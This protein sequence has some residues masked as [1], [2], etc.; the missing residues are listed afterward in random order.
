MNR[1]IRILIVSRS[2]W[3]DDNSTGNTLS[4]FFGGQSNLEL[5]N[6]YFRSG[7]PSNSVCNRYFSLSEMKLFGKNKGEFEC[8]DRDD[9][10]L[11]S[12]EEI[13]DQGF[14]SKERKVVE[15]VRRYKSPL[16]FLFQDLFWLLG[17]WKSIDF[18]KFL[19]DFKPDVIFFPSF[20]P[21]YTHKV[22][23][24]VL[25]RTGAKL[26]VFHTDDYIFFDSD[27]YS[28]LSGFYLKFRRE[29]IERTARLAD[30]N[31]CITGVQAKAYQNHLG[32]PFKVIYKGANLETD[33]NCGVSLINSP[34]TR[35]VIRILYAGSLLYGRWKALS[36]LLDAVERTRDLSVSFF[37]DIYSQYE[38]SGEMLNAIVRDGYSAFHG[39]VDS[40]RLK[41]LLASSD[42]VLH[43]ESFDE[44]DI[45][46]TKYSF[47]TKIVDCLA[48]GAC[49]L[50]VGPE[51]VASIDYLLANDVALV[52]GAQDR[53]E[54][55]LRSVHK[56]PNL[57]YEY[58]EKA[59]TFVVEHHDLSRIRSRLLEDINSIIA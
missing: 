30:L 32:I 19:D 50:G 41:K 36:L 12:R 24:F 13:E 31:Y 46:T 14:N 9:Q 52:A 43:A 47:S 29:R 4:N 33:S 37:L 39:S 18:L 57:M 10:S 28:F 40:A 27:K 54:V 38:P 22:V 44:E 42:M 58:A 21:I 1:K 15:Y 23:E 2:E 8:Y 35:K 11:F 7:A 51:E 55:V 5:A 53:I 26:M 45:A 34:S 49:V 59:R 6:L 48:S 20:H 16:L 3:R 17:W 25:Q 56:H